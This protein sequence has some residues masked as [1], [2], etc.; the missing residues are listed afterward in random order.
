MLMKCN[1]SICGHVLER[2]NAIR[3]F[4]NGTIN[5]GVGQVRCPLCQ[6]NVKSFVYIP[7]LN[8][9]ITQLRNYKNKSKMQK[10]YI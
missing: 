6:L 10:L 5:N 3:L 4:R 8:E 9:M 1:G 7:L 2:S